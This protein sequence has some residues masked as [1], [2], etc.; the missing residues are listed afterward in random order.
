TVIP[1]FVLGTIILLIKKGTAHH[2]KLGKIYMV[3]MTFTA[4][5]TLFMPAEVGPRIY[6]HFGWIHSLSFLTIFVV[7]Y[8]YL[9]IKNGRVSSHKRSMIL[10]YVGAILIAGGFTFYPGRYLYSIFFGG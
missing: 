6:N 9:S 5:V 7:P 8:S 2:K 3:L 10:L 4:A 1:C